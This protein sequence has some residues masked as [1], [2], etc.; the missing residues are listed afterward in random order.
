MKLLTIIFLC[1]TLTILIADSSFTPWVGCFYSSAGY[2]TLN[3]LQDEFVKENS[4]HLENKVV[5]SFESMPGFHLKTMKNKGTLSF[6]SYLEYSSTGGRIDYRDYSG[7]STL[8]IILNHNAIGL[9]VE[10]QL[11]QNIHPR[12]KQYFSLGACFDQLSFISNTKLY[13]VGSQST[14]DYLYSMGIIG[15]TGISYDI[16]NKPF[17]LRVQA[18]GQLAYSQ[19]FHL[20]GNSEAQLQTEKSKVSPDWSGFRAALLLGW[21][22]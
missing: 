13:G 9:I 20:K 14:T 7:Y 6:G 4:Y 3:E 21:V 17:L 18:G 16:L 11:I 10:D 12:F 1:L 22:F 19:P 15:A 2:K 8:D 5:D